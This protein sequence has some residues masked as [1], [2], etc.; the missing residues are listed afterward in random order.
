M[1]FPDRSFTAEISRLATLSDNHVRENPL[2]DQSIL[3]AAAMMVR[4]PIS[5]TQSTNYK[6]FRTTDSNSK[7][8]PVANILGHSWLFWRFLC[9]R[10]IRRPPSSQYTTEPG[11]RHCDVDSI[12]RFAVAAGGPFFLVCVCKCA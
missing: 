5:A 12:D 8:S 1:R 4:F 11:E 10:P 2:C 3:V 9:S 6:M 7:A